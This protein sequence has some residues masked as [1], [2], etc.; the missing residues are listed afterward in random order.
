MEFNYIEDGIDAVVIDN[1]FTEKQLQQIMVELKWLTKQE[2]MVDES[3][4]FSSADIETGEYQTS[5][6]GIFLER[7]F[8]NW[9]H[10]ALISAPFEQF[11]EDVVNK[12]VSFNSLFKLLVHCDTRNHLLSYYE[13]SDYYKAHLDT[14]VF[15]VLCYFFVE[16]KQFDGGDLT[17]HSF[18]GK[19]K[20][21]I[22]IKNNRVVIITGNTM[23]EVKQI[24]SKMDNSFSGK[25]RYCNAIFLSV[26][27]RI[28]ELQKAARAKLK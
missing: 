21:E 3:D 4:L 11:S 15:T 16:P 23:H 28:P 18:D 24:T 7:V 12:I 19:R 5:K 14:T 27:D 25:G 13:N 1:F 26:S 10:S 6:N 22:E 20:A 8:I 17:L 2:I 9:K